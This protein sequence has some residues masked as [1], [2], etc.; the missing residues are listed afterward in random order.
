MA[1]RISQEIRDKIVEKIKNDGLSVCQAAK[2]FGVSTNAIYGWLGKGKIGTDTLELG[3]LRRE[4]QQLKLIIA[5]VM[6]D[7]GK[8]K[9]NR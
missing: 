5:E 1:K 4:N 3:K 8:G 9:K 7:S 2:E 6:L